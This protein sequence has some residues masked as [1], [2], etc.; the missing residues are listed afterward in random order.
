MSVTASVAVL[1]VRVIWAVVVL[2]ALKVPTVLAPLSVVPPEELVVSVSVVLIRP[3]PVSDKAPLAVR[4][5]A[6]FAR[7]EERRVGK[8]ARVLLTV[9][10]SPTESLMPLLTSVAGVVV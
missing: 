9:T 4:L 7:S 8:E 6:P 3:A 2:S 10:L 5:M 1:L